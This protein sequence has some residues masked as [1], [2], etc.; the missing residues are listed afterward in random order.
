[1]EAYGIVQ[2]HE[3]ILYMPKADFIALGVTKADIFIKKY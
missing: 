1:M 2:K 3:K